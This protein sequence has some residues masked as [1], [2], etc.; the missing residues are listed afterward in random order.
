MAEHSIPSSVPGLHDASWDQD[1][2]PVIACANCGQVLCDGCAPKQAHEESD[3]RPKARGTLPWEHKTQGSYLRS[4]T[5]TALETA[6]PDQAC[7]R[8]RQAGSSLRALHFALAAETLAITSFALPW[9][10][11]FCALFPKLA[12]RLAHSP[13]AVAIVGLILG[14]LI[15]GVVMLHMVWGGALEWAI[16]RQGTPAAYALGQRFGFY[17][18]GWDLLSSPAG[19]LLVSVYQGTSAARSALSAGIAVPRH[20]LSAYLEE[21]RAIAAAQHRSVVRTCFGL[22]SVVFLAGLLGAPTALWF[23]L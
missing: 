21:G 9:A 22:T 7:F 20:A 8:H 17:A 23:W 18:C 6:H 14:V 2:P 15:V 5:L 10:L 3:A 19:L 13:Q 1:V 16:A 12:L 11:G 4:L